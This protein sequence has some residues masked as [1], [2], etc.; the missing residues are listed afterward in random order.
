MPHVA[1]GAELIVAPWLGWIPGLPLLAFVVL[2]LAGRRLG[3][4]SPWIAVAAMAL[5][6]ALTLSIA[7]PIFHGVRF[8]VRWSWFPEFAA[9]W[10]GLPESSRWSLGLAVDG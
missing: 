10:P 9:R 1:V 2:I 6:C 3:R 8:A 7:R 4:V 5:A